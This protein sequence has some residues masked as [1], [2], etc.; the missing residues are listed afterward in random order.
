MNSWNVGYEN[1]V[2]ATP[3]LTCEAFDDDV[4]SVAEWL[5]GRT[6]VVRTVAGDHHGVIVETE[7][8][9]GMDDPA[10][11]AAFRPGG[12][13]AIM[14]GPPGS[15][16]V[17]AAYGMYPCFNI[18]TGPVGVASA[19]LIRGIRTPGAPRSILGPGRTTRALG[20]TLQDHGDTVCGQRFGVS[21]ERLPLRTVATPR[22]GITRGRELP[23]RFIW[24]E[25][26]GTAC[27][28]S[29]S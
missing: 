8:Y 7:A 19:V 13:A 12:R 1:L 23:W 14:A 24:D 29:T 5:I 15:V 25:L 26:N 17:Y 18:V 9:A 27:Q 4:V 11:H 20:I 6:L 16:Y 28:A 10:S 3:F 2:D 22:I 21:A